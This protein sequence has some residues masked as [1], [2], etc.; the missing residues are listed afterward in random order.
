MSVNE[1]I[2]AVLQRERCMPPQRSA[3]EESSH[4]GSPAKCIQHENAEGR[5]ASI[6]TIGRDRYDAMTLRWSASCSPASTSP[7]SCIL[8]GL[9]P[10]CIGRLR[11][12]SQVLYAL[13]SLNGWQIIGLED[14]TLNLLR[15][16][17]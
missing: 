6:T 15:V 17:K 8:L 9:R 5:I 2:P 3:N 12:K 16:L 14:A 10:D 11:A 1:V 4:S 7:L 13:V